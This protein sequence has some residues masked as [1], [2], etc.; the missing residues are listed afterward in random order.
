MTVG[1]MLTHYDLMMLTHYDLMMLLTDN[2][3]EKI[4]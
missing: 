1:K 2:L 3:P 4:V